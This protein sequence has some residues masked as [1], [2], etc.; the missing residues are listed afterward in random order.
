MSTSKAK[1]EWRDGLKS[2]AG[3]MGSSH[4]E[5]VS[6]SLKKRLSEEAGS[7][8]EEFL[9]AALCGC[10]SMA[11]AAALERES[12]TPKHVSTEAHVRLERDEVGLKIAAIALVTKARVE[13]IEPAKFAHI[14]RATKESCPVAKA[15]LGTS[16]TVDASLV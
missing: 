1:A 5:P 14:V 3:T 9:G 7:S 16:V 2:G 11:L 6:F 15:L 4:I 10:F 12:A 8:P 13:N